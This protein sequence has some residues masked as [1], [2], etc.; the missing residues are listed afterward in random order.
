MG[1]IVQD[2]KGKSVK[3]VMG[4]YGIG[5]ERNMAAVVE[6]NHDENGICWPVNVAPYEVVVTVVK[7]KEVDCHEAGERLYEKLH[8][9]GIDVIIDDRKE[10]PGVKFKD[11]DLIGFPYRVTVGPKGIADGIFEFVR[12]KDGQTREL[13][14]E[15]AAEMI[16]EEVLDH[17]F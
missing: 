15:H 3:L 13:P 11:A 7:P 12:R 8:E 2:E 1:A 16:I 5:L 4:S 9:A 10:R 17:R 14:I 6:A